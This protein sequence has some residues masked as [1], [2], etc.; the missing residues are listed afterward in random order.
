MKIDFCDDFKI[1]IGLFLKSCQKSDFKFSWCKNGSNEKYTGG[2]GVQSLVLKII[3]IVGIEKDFDVNAISQSIMKYQ[4]A[5][6]FFVG[7]NRN[8]NQIRAETRQ[9]IS[10]LK[11][12]KITPKYKLEFMDRYNDIN[13][14]ETFLSGFDWRNPWSAGSHMSHLMFFLDFCEKHEMNEWIKEQYLPRLWR[15]NGWYVGDN[16]DQ[17]ININGMMKVISGLVASKKT[18]PYSKEVL[19]YCIKF[20]G[21]HN[22]CNI[23]DII[24][25]LYYCS[26]YCHDFDKEIQEVFIKQIEEIK[27]HWKDDGFSFFRSASQKTYLNDNNITKGLNESDVHGTILFLWAISLINDKL[28]MGYDLKIQTT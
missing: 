19:A 21:S 11:N 9:A 27:K 26:Q 3:Y 13:A 22:A 24:F 12:Y 14:I 16:I 10:A 15:G 20:L 8:D 17:S 5:D 2:L 28:N 7:G 4:K 25:C 23:M 1:R 6:G 18:I